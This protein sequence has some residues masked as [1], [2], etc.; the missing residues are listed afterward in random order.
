MHVSL[1]R[2]SKTFGENAAVRSVSLQIAAGEVVA[3]LGENGA[4]KSTLMKVLYGVYPPTDGE[5]IIDG[6]KKIFSTPADAQRAGLGMVF[7]AFNLIPNLTATENLMLSSPETGWFTGGRGRSRQAAADAIYRMGNGL[8]PEAR[9]GDLAVGE[10]QLLELIRVVESNASLIILDEPTSVLT[11]SETEALYKRVRELASAGKAVVFITHK[12]EDVVACATRVCVLRRGE[13]VAE[14]KTA[15]ITKAAL[16]NHFVGNDIACSPVERPAKTAT[17]LYIKNLS[18]ERDHDR[19]EEIDFSLERG[20]ILGVA[21]ISG[22]GQRLLADL[23]VGL[24]SPTTGEVLL[25]GLSLHEPGYERDKIC[26]IPEQPRFNAVAEDLDLDLNLALKRIRRLPWWNTTSVE[27]V[28]TADRLKRFDVRPPNPRLK[29]GALSGGNLQK[30]VLARELGQACDMVVA[31]YPTM[32]L[33][34]RA[35]HSVH[36]YLLEQAEQGA[37]VIWISED[38]DELLHYTHRI[39]VLSRGKLL[40]LG[41]TADTNR[42]KIGEWML[43]GR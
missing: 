29:A 11:P 25:D 32:G 3:L 23:L 39:G 5:I 35:I 9:V 18:G 21:G 27:P 17:R 37:C 10:Q 1:E 42:S 40:G 41:A 28:E 4:G 43:S 36:R 20:E 31:C 33:D 19:V 30:L 7:Q 6:V 12:M 16:V 8:D 34:L 26:Y 2:V 15:E 22:S 13:L 38:L 24:Y 14:L